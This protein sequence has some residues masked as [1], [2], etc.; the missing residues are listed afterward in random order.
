MARP[1]KAKNQ[2]AAKATKKPKAKAAESNGTPP[3]RQ[4]VERKHYMMDL[5]VKVGREQVEQAAE[6]FAAAYSEREATLE[7]RREAM[8]GFK[9]TLT[10][11]DERMKRLRDTVQ[12]HTTLQPVE[13]VERLIVETN[14]VEVVR[15]DTGEIVETKTASAEDRQESLFEAP[16]DD[17]G[18]TVDLDDPE[19]LAPGPEFGRSDAPTPGVHG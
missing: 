9:E 3:L 6:E 16:E 14:A 11:I 8:A 12:K 15:L 1:K 4:P 13:V 7:E 19:S 5:P 17:G 2:A 18:E 10:G